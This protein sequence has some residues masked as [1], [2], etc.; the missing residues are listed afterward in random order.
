[1]DIK[2]WKPWNWFKKEE[3][4]AAQSLP[5]RHGEDFTNFER[6]H[7]PRNRMHQEMDRIFSNM[8]RDFDRAPFAMGKFALP[9]SINGMLT[10]NLDLGVTDKAYTLNVEIPGVEEKDFKLEIVNDTLIIQGE[11]KQ[12]QEEKGKDYYR[13]ERAYGAFRRVLCLPEDVNQEGIKA[14]FTKGVLTIQM[15]RKALPKAHARQIAVQAA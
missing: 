1:M 3:E 11:K 12:E 9:R 2:K 10:P 5:A 4:G 8:F 13:V 15:P 14:H 6:L 7:S